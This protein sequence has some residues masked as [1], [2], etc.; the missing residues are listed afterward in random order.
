VSDEW[1]TPERLCEAL[2]EFDLDPCASAFSHVRARTHYSLVHGQNGLELPWV[3]S[4]FCNPPYSRP[5]I[6][7]FCERLSIH[8]G[9]WV[10]LVKLD[11]TTNWWRTLTDGAEWSPFRRRIKFE[12]VRTFTAPFPSALVWHDWA[13]PAAMYD[14]IYRVTIR[15]A[16][17]SR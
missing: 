17:A 5:G 8:D 11:P 6:N 3:G 7:R 9:P 2:G 14:W 15:G 4:V 10:A 12:G 16:D 1:C 13:P